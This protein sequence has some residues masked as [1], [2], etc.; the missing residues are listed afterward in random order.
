MKTA[1]RLQLLSA[2]RENNTI[3]MVDNLYSQR[4]MEII[5]G[6]YT[7]RIVKITK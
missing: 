2:V 3:K 4:I 5:K 7:D 1:N 6:D